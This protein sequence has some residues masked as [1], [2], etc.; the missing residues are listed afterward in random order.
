MDLPVSFSS[1]TGRTPQRFRSPDI[2]F[3]SPSTP[4]GS[5]ASLT[6]SISR[7][8]EAVVSA[9]SP[10]AHSVITS[11]ALRVLSFLSTQEGCH[12]GGYEQGCKADLLNSSPQPDANADAQPSP[13]GAGL[14]TT[15]D[16]PAHGTRPVPAVHESRPSLKND[17]TP[18]RIR[19][20]KVWDAAH[21]GRSQLRRVTA[22]S[23]T[24]TGRLRRSAARNRS[25]PRRPR[26]AYLV[27]FAGARTRHHGS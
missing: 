14:R 3:I 25:E 2:N 27:H 19:L 5:G 23:G 15:V 17:K 24:Y 10:V 18:G 8:P 6:Y 1:R 21:H 26:G 13:R 11:M 4:S 22:E 20:G 16:L 12:E 9:G 7:L